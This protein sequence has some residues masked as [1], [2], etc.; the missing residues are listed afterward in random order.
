MNGM[1]TAEMTF[2]A[3]Y[4]AGATGY[5][6]A[7]SNFL[8]EVTLRFHSAVTQG[9]TSTVHRILAEVIEPICRLRDRRKGYAVSYVKAAVN[10]RGNIEAG[11]VRPPLTDLTSDEA[12]ELRAIIESAR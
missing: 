5:S 12:E 2:P 4:A 6:S 3:Y 1:P 8:P 11:P 7:L 9:D 10:L